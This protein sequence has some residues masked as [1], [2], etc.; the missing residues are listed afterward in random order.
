VDTLSFNMRRA[1]TVI[2][3]DVK[4]FTL[5][6]KGIFKFYSQTKKSTWGFPL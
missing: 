4:F 3:Q 1:V 6:K 2:Q 5:R